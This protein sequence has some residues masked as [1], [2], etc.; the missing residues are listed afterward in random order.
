MIPDIQNACKETESTLTGQ[1]VEDKTRLQSE[2]EDEV[3][4]TI[5]AWMRY[6]KFMEMIEL[7][8]LEY[9]KKIAI[10]AMF[11]GNDLVYMNR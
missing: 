9:N 8:G 11:R 7:R 1:E 10:D 2:E 5:T 4:M 6:Q 3:T